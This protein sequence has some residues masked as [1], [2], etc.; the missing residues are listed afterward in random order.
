MK[1]ESDLPKQPITKAPIKGLPA[2]YFVD[3]DIYD[4][5]KHQVYF[6]TWQYACHTSQVANHGDYYSLS[7]FDQDIFIIRD[8][9]SQLKAMYNVCQHRGHRLVEG[10]GNK[11]LVVCPYHAWSYELN[12]K[13][14]GAPNSQ[15]VSGFDTSA[16]CIPAIRLE[17]FL[18]FVFVNLDP[19]CVSMDRTFPGVREG[20]LQLCPDIKNKKFASEHTADEG[21]NWLTAVE[22]Y[23]E[24][25]HCKVAHPDF[26]T[27]VIDPDSYCVSA[28]GEGK[29][30]RHES[31]ATQ[32]DQAWYDVSGSDYG[33]FFLWPSCSIQ[34]YPGGVVNTY[35][36]RPLC[37]DD[38]CVHRGWFSGDGKVDETLQKIIDLDRDTTFS[39]DLIL[40]KNVQ[41]GLKSRGYQP[42]PLIIDPSGG[43]DN[44][45]SISKLH[46]WLR[47]AVDG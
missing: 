3:E 44:E 36:W 40:V 33:S 31:L 23:N 26:A 5:V 45:L 25:Y 19:E 21:C 24:C 28:F 18:G 47:Q 22:N 15:S 8:K 6:K 11:K 2:K 29:V 13:L 35:H 42:G 27:G 4:K 30:L 46:S 39:E 9:D 20:I 43:I 17:E 1:P 37:V 41:R 38:V 12:G 32:S 7:I 16:I 14:R 10:T 34:I